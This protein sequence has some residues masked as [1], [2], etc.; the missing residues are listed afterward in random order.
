MITANSFTKMDQHEEICPLPEPIRLQDLLNSA[1][2]RAEKKINIFI[3]P[4]LVKNTFVLQGWQESH[5]LYSV[6]NVAV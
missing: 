2:S 6:Y 4:L 5:L 1:R 3:T